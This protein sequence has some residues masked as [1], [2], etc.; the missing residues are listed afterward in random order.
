MRQAECRAVEQMGAEQITV[1]INIYHD[2]YTHL[3]QEFQM[4]V[5]LM[6]YNNDNIEIIEMLLKI[7]PL[8]LAMAMVMASASAL[9]VSSFLSLMLFI[10]THLAADAVPTTVQR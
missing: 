6:E 2:F 4:N 5:C 9:L 3:Y 10:Y 7:G 8:E 1:Y